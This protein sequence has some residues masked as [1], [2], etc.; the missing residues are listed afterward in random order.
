M[1][2]VAG[3]GAEGCQHDGV[4]RRWDA[5]HKGWPKRANCS[6]E[7]SAVVRLL[8]QLSADR[9]PTFSRRCLPS[10]GIDQLDKADALPIPDVYSITLEFNSLSHLPMVSR[11]IPSS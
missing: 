6:K 7:D 10:V 9:L 4:E 5:W 1:D 2:S 11:D 8:D 3:D